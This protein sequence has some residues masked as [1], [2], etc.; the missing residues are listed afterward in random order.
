MVQLRHSVNTV[1]ERT[2]VKQES[3]TIADSE[4][5]EE[6]D[7]VTSEVDCEGC[8]QGVRNGDQGQEGSCDVRVEPRIQE[9]VDCDRAKRGGGK[10]EAKCEQ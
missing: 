8:L 10:K 9:R 2:G 4:A 5:S 3:V 1:K 7:T 6:H